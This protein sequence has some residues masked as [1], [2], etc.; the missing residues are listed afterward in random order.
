[1]KESHERPLNGKDFDRVLDTLRPS[2]SKADL[3]R[4][5]KFRTER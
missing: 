5:R 2:V 4:F 1:M 3:E